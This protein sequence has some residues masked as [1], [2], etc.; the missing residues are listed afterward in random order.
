LTGLGECWKKEMNNK[1]TSS[2]G[3]VQIKEGRMGG[4]WGTLTKE[5]HPYRII[6]W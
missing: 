5:R 2:Y 4:V 3:D 6:S 1:C